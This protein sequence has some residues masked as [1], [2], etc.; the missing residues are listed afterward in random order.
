LGLLDKAMVAV[1]AGELSPLVAGTVYCSVIDACQEVLEWRGA[2]EWQHKGRTSTASLTSK[3]S[4]VGR[5][6]LRERSPARR[7]SVTDAGGMQAV[8][9]D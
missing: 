9:V 6:R 7:S 8:V 3:A 2:Q 4:L 1:V 5:S